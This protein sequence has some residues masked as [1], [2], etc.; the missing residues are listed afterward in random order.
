MNA[1]ETLHLRRVQTARPKGSNLYCLSSTI[2]L[3]QED[4]G[5]GLNWDLGSASVGPPIADSQMSCRLLPIDS[6]VRIAGPSKT[7]AD[8]IEFSDRMLPARSL[9]V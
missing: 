7:S 2:D 8:R 1:A 5:S 9:S 4:T 3:R 6:T